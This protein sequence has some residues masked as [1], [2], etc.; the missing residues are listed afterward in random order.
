VQKIKINQTAL[1]TIVGFIATILGTIGTA[2][3]IFGER[4]AWVILTGFGLI[5]L[6]WILQKFIKVVIV[7]VKTGD[8]K[9]TLEDGML[10][11]GNEP[12][13]ALRLDTVKTLFDSIEN[14]ISEPKEFKYFSKQLGYDIGLN[15]GRFLKREIIRKGERTLIR[16]G[17]F[18]KKLELWIK[19]DSTTGLGVFQIDKLEHIQGKIKGKLIVHNSF[20]IFERTREE[21]YCAF[22][23][24]YIQAIIY[25]FTNININVIEIE[26]GCVTSQSQ[27]IFE[28]SSPNDI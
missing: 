8:N 16:Q 25:I 2:Y 13:V 14:L 28:I 11:I 12:N 26:C 17:N 9:W 23:E 4:I 1:I 21:P 5:L 18:A 27:C 6:I 19:Y 7:T 24:G 10:L 3:Q 15:F 22:M 20:I